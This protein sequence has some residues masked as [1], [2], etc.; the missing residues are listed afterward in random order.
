MAKGPAP[1]ISD[2]RRKAVI[3][4]AEIS[5]ATDAFLLDRKA[6]PYRFESGHMLDVAAA[7][8]AHRPAKAALAEKTIPDAL[9]RTMVR[10][11]VILA[12]PDGGQ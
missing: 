4:D 3:T 6:K 5:A 2:L 12:T 8:E 7:V 10:T 11:A 9:R 1:T